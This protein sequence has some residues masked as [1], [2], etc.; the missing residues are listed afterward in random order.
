MTV[1][2]RARDDVD[3]R[4]A[5][6]RGQPRRLGREDPA[7]AVDD[8]P[9][10]RRRRIRSRSAVIS[11]ASWTRP[12]PRYSRMTSRNV[13]SWGMVMPNW[14]TGTGPD[15]LDSVSTHGRP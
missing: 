7:G 12:S 4:V 10:T 9:A 2:A 1:E 14:S 8:R 3:A 11:A 15:G 5:G 13:C 6:E